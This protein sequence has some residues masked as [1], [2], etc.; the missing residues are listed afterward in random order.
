MLYIDPKG[1]IDCEA[2]V[3]RCPVEAIFRDENVPDAWK[4]FIQ[5][6][7]DMAPRCEVI[8]EREKPRCQ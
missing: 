3:P 4:E 2:C 7:A 5:I 1:C 8:T 6:N